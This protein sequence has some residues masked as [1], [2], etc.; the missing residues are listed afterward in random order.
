MP[1]LFFYKYYISQNNSTKAIDTKPEIV[2]NSHIN[3]ITG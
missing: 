1:P 2:Q 3:Q